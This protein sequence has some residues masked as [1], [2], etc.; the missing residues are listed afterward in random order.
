MGA[1]QSYDI[2]PL[3]LA[4]IHTKSLKDVEE[5]WIL[6][7]VNFSNIVRANI[8]DIIPI[9]D[10]QIMIYIINYCTL[11]LF[12]VLCGRIRT[13]YDAIYLDCKYLPLIMS[14]RYFT[15][16]HF[17][18]LLKEIECYR[19][20]GILDYDRLQILLKYDKYMTHKLIIF[21]MRMMRTISKLRWHQKI[22]SFEITAD[23]DYIQHIE[24]MKL[25]AVRILDTPEKFN[26]YYDEFEKMLECNLFDFEYSFHFYYNDC[27]VNNDLCDLIMHC[28]KI[29]KDTRICTI[30]LS[31]LVKQ[32]KSIYTKPYVCTPEGN[33][34]VMMQYFNLFDFDT[35][36]LVSECK[37]HYKNIIENGTQHK[38]IN[39]LII[40]CNRQ[41]IQ[42]M[43]ATDMHEC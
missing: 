13:K 2:E 21:T 32:F 39:D 37:R 35:C 30:L 33:T 19:K 7:N 11:D 40:K 4:A 1:S 31:C 34:H 28:I 20:F 43:H 29:G 27:R 17:N 12:N 5:L 25:I 14:H 18:K 16:K 38:Q 8:T 3:L 23:N 9:C 24:T 6:D 36:K 42:N 15:Q 41:N 22:H 26:K 10:E